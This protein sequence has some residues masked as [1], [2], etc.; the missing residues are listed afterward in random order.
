MTVGW[1]DVVCEGAVAVDE[2][3]ISALT[4]RL[5]KGPGVSGRVFGQ[6]RSDCRL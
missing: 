4:G 3:Y 1:R 2:C 5:T 6:A